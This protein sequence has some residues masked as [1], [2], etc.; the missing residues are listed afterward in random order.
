MSQGNSVADYKITYETC[1]FCSGYGK[2]VPR[3]REELIDIFRDLDK[4]LWLN[5]KDY[6]SMYRYWKDTGDIECILCNGVGRVESW[7]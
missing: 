4:D 1:S 3:N 5:F 6:L 7:S 2:L